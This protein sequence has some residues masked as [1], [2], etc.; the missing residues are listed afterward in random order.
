MAVP[1]WVRRRHW[2]LLEVHLWS[3]VSRSTWVLGIELGSSAR[4]VSDLGG[5]LSL[6]PLEQLYVIPKIHA[7]SPCLPTSLSFL[8]HMIVSLR[9]YSP[10]TE[11]GEGRCSV[12]Q[13]VY[14]CLLS[15]GN[16]SPVRPSLVPD[17]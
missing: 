1:T 7:S 9:N 4:A 8:G 5:K 13:G 11:A 6:Q 16:Y 17:S 14:P 12:G 15:R 10:R 2:D 3:L